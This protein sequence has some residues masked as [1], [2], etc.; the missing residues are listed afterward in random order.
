M[1]YSRPEL[2]AST[3]K[4][5][6]ARMVS[7]IGA[8]RDGRLVAME[9][10]GDFNTGAYASWGPTVA[11]RVPV[12]ASG[13]YVVPHYLA[14]SR[15]ILTNCVPAGAFRGFGVPQ[16]V[17]AQEQL[18]D[19]LG[20]QDRHGPAGVPDT[21]CAMRD[22]TPT[23]TGQIM[24]EGVGYRDCL[25]ALR[26]PLAARTRGGAGVQRAKRIHAPGRRGRR[27]VLRLRQYVPAQPLDHAHRSEARW[28]DSLAPGR[29]G[30]RPGIEHC[31]PA[32]R[33]RR[34]GLAAFADRPRVSADTDLTPDCGK[35]SASTADVRDRQGGGARRPG[36][37]RKNA[38]A[39]QRRRGQA[40]VEIRRRS[41]RHYRRVGC[42]RGRT[43]DAAATMRRATC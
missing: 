20:A 14:E 24:G 2:F 35:T 7:R 4:R 22:D 13:P 34:I 41:H 19:A 28:A 15:A 37:A 12:H 8:D 33:R 17:I 6:P 23:V 9:F 18:L 10:H 21:Q 1:V 11:N 26:S 38:P 25:E 32:N 30:Y 31:H 3:T 42:P 5:H 40:R 39:R 16:T 43:L 36:A 29:G 27:H